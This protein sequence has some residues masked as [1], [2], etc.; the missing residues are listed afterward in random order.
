M[1][2]IDRLALRAGNEKKEGEEADTVGCCS[3][4]F[5]HIKLEHP[6]IVHFDFLGKDSIRYQ[7]TVRVE[8]QIYKNLKVFKKNRESEKDQ[9]FDRVN[10]SIF[11]YYLLVSF[12]LIIFLR[13]HC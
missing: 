11:L 12:L 8:D 7:N 13:L 5:E 2:F 3:L 10:V 1:Y 4:R 9:L 6:D